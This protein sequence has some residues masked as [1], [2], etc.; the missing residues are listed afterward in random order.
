MNRLTNSM[1]NDAVAQ[2]NM[3][4]SRSQ[5]MDTNVAS[6]TVQFTRDQI[7]LQAG[8]S[9][10]AQA[11]QAPT[12]LLGLLRSR[13]SLG[14]GAWRHPPFLKKAVTGVGAPSGPRALRVG[15]RPSD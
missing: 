8:T 10:L 12:S 5:I 13:R 6:T 11:N 14:D 4:S 1:N 7:L 3:L 15:A 2:E 9:I